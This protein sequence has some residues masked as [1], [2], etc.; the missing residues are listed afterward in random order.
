EGG[1][2][3]PMVSRSVPDVD[4]LVLLA[5]PGVPG[6]SLLQLQV[7]RIAAAS[8]A[9]AATVERQ[10]ARQRAIQDI[11]KGTD[12]PEEAAVQIQRAVR[13]G[14]EGMT[15]DERRSA[16]LDDPVVVD[17]VVARSARQVLSPWFRY[18]LTHDPRPEL[19][20]L[21]IPV[22]VLLG[23]KDVQV[24]PEENAPALRSALAESA[25]DVR[26]VRVMSGLN[27]LFQHAETGL[28]AEYGRIEETMAPEALEAISTW[29]LEVV[30]P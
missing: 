9:D 22:L 10:R 23:E 14:I 24:P 3:A 5:P 27:H 16:G 11:V 29:I 20:A 8:G 19:R 28:P 21:R 18:F 6:D 2:I 4:W 30:R 15:P 12:D 25:A 13:E 26:D 17:S 7:A 1:L